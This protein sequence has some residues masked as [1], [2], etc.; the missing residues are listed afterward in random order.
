M[1]DILQ[2]ESTHM[3]VEMS[4]PI[5]TRRFTL[6]DGMIAIGAIALGLAPLQWMGL[7]EESME[8]LGSMN[9]PFLSA[10]YL[11]DLVM[12]SLTLVT[13]SAMAMT[14]SFL[15]LRLRQPRLRW[16]RLVRQP[17]TVASLALVLSWLFAGA[18]ASIILVGD[19][20]GKPIMASTGGPY[21]F[22]FR[23]WVQS[24]TIYS[25][26]LGGFA[27][28]VAWSTQRL[29]GR[30]RAEA[31]WVDRLGRLVGVVWIV[32]GIVA[33]YVLRNAAIMG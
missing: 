3:D 33:L 32:I 11:D 19:M 20:T 8:S 28:V 23:D 22:G 21:V 10:T 26:P 6:L 24:F 12:V 15:V 25:P 4:R 29:L 2:K 9:S 17:G 30:W 31:S 18:F 27:V 14:M 16:C 1:N 7:G 5:A 13:P